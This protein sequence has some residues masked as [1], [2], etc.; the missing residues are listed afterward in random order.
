MSWDR[1][2]RKNS[3]LTIYLSSIPISLFQSFV[4]NSK[5]YIN[6]LFIRQGALKRGVGLSS[7]PQRKKLR[8]EKR[9]EEKRRE[10]K[11]R[12]EKRREEKRREE[13]RREEKR[14]DLEDKHWAVTAI[15]GKCY[16]S[17]CKHIHTHTHTHT[18]TPPTLHTHN[19]PYNAACKD[20]TISMHDCALTPAVPLQNTHT[21]RAREKKGTKQIVRHWL[22]HALP[23][24]SISLQFPKQYI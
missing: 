17:I 21:Q 4:F 20:R 23:F 12:E 24:D 13:K 10:E 7:K 15:K 19:V 9:R 18:N 3:S 8:W 22:S 1:K 14:R 11:R 6:T 16:D 2:K 5:P